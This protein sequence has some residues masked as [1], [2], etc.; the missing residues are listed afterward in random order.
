MFSIFPC[1]LLSPMRGKL[2]NAQEELLFDPTDAF[3]DVVKN[4]STELQELVAAEKAF[5]GQKSRVNWIQ[6]GDMNTRF[7]FT[8]LWL[9]GTIVIKSGIWFLLMVSSFILFHRFEV[10]TYY[11]SHLGTKDAQVVGCPTGVLQD[12][13]PSISSLDADALCGPVTRVSSFVVE[14]M[15][16]K[17]RKCRQ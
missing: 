1:K 15:I 14:L 16:L 12:L 10:V 5:Y 17:R 11:K 4:L 13:L 2:A 8:S 6:Q 3:I 9:Q 7:F